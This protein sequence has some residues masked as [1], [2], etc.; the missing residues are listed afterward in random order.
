VSDIPLVRNA[1]TRAKV[2]KREGLKFLVPVKLSWLYEENKREPSSNALVDTS[3]EATIF[4]TDFVEQMMMPWV[5]R[6]TRLR[7]ESAEGSIL[8]RLGTVQ[9][10]NVEICMPDTR[11]GK[12]KTLDLVTEVACLEPGCPLILGFDWITTQCDKL[13]VTTP[14]GLELKRALEIE[15]VMDFSEFDEILEQSSYVSLI[16]VGKWES[17]RLSTGKACK[18]MQ[19]I[20]GEDLKTLAERLPVQY[21]DFVEIFGKATQASLPAHVPQDIVID[22]KPGKQPPSGKLYPLS[23]DELELLNEYLDEILRT[24]KIWPSKSSAGAPIF[25]A[26]QANGKLRIVVDY[27]GLN[28]ITI[29]DKYPLPL[30]TTL[31]EQVGTSQVFSKL[32]LKLGFNLLRIAEADE[33]KTAFKTRYGLYEYTVMPFGL[34]NTPSV[35]QRHLN[36]ILSEKID[37]SMV[38]YIDNILIYT[39][40]EEEHVELMRWVLKILSENSLCV[41]IDKCIFHVPEVEFVGFQIGT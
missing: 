19:I 23:P 8:K 28:A 31:M 14:Y 33:W 12:N 6:E 11:S 13:T 2:L 3:A 7:L 5:K 36:N 25:F 27:R 17:R 1:D 35:F 39:Q 9:V 20:V 21:T 22:L 34:T 10:K 15:E 16:H 40:T 30:M 24:G 32:D 29:K 18:I 4:D 26:K 41:N 38:V 37:H